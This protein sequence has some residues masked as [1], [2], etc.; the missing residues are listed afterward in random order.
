MD[1]LKNVMPSLKNNAKKWQTTKS[2][3]LQPSLFKM[4][5]VAFLSLKMPVVLKPAGNSC[6]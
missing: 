1:K 4:P 2:K 6:N 5:N 3:F